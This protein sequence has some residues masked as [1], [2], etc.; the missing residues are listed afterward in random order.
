MQWLVD[1][2]NGAKKAAEIIRLAG[3]TVV[4]RTRFQKLAYLL[5]ISGCGKG[6]SFEYR[7]YGPYSEDL[8]RAT[9]VASLIGI[10]Q[11]EE[12]S[13][14]W[15]GTYSIFTT[16]PSAEL[17][18]NHDEQAKALTRIAL[19][20]NPIDLEL[21]ATAAF[22]AHEKCPDPWQETSRRKPEK[23]SRLES[24]KTLYSRLSQLML[25]ISLPRI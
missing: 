14:N 22:L 12:R 9:S 23:S 8:T 11:E 4:G 15:G 24:A 2:P 10:I 5:E 13:A 7:H 6:F 25:P 16:P 21:A 19:D 20:A 18:A 3:G 1:G 17:T